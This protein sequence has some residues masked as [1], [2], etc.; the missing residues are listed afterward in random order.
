MVAYSNTVMPVL[1]HR[2]CLGVAVYNETE[3]QHKLIAM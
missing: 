1:L 3:N 2:H